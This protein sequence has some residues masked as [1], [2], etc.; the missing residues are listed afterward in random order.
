MSSK[1]PRD[2]VGVKM[3]N[4]VQWL[5]DADYTHNN[6]FKCIHHK[7]LACMV[8]R[9]NWIHGFCFT[10]CWSATIANVSCNYYTP[11]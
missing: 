1:K 10:P 9:R 6:T 11:K 5:T 7:R 2:T 4:E 8:A 3:T